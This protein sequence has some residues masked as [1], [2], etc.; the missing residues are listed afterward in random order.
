MGT[1]AAERIAAAE[2]ADYAAFLADGG[3]VWPRGWDPRAWP[4]AAQG[5]ATRQRGA[6]GSGCASVSTR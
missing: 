4:L 6:T 2:G 3:C 5:L 1:E